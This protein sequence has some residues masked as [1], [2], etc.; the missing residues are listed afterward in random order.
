V[1]LSNY[2]GSHA[3]TDPK[4]LFRKAMSGQV[5]EILVWKAF[6]DHD[7]DPSLRSGQAL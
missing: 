2:S 4:G 1:T 5:Q 3:N 7:E 6:F